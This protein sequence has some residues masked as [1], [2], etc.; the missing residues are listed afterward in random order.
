MKKI[1]I[2]YLTVS[3]ILFH[4]AVASVIYTYPERLYSAFYSVND[5]LALKF[6]AFF[7]SDAQLAANT[8]FAISQVLPDWRP[9]DARHGVPP[10]HA[11]IGN[12]IY[13]DPRKAFSSLQKGETL[14]IGPG[15]YKQSTVITASNVTIEGDGHVHFSHAYAQNKGNFVIKGNDVFLRN[16][17]CSRIRVPH[18]NGSC[19]RHEGENLTVERVYF[20]DSQQGILTGNSPGLVVIR[21]SRFER[22]GKN[23]QAHGIYIGGGRLFIDDSIFLAS[24]SEGHEIKSRA[25]STL[26]M[27]SIIASLDGKDSRLIDIPNG[28]DFSLINSLLEQG[29]YSRNG[30]VIGYALER[31]AT[32]GRVSIKNNTFILERLGHNRLFHAN[33]PVNDFDFSGNIIVS[34]ELQQSFKTPLEGSYFRDRES[35]GL[36]PYPS[37]PDRPK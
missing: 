1:L 34:S 16:I 9:L 30:D 37:L 33:K 27:N 3:G 28:G 35:A 17:E 7:A 21:E 8:D 24:K 2:G 32:H 36:P 25:T 26:I 29:P 15:H 23:G 20:H 14:L 13:D 5:W 6:P 4:I 19:I 10:G 12:R 11:R 22:L 31:G 18:K